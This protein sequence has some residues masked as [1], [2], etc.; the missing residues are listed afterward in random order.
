MHSAEPFVLEALEQGAS[1]YVLK[2][3]GVAELVRAIRETVER[4]A[5]PEPAALRQ[6]GGGLHSDGG[7]R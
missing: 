1:A 7:A 2:D 5:L 6:G 4:P 3:G